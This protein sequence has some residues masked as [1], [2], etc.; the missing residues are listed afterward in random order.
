MNTQ[1][2]WYR[3][4]G[5]ML[6]FVVAAVVSLKF[7][8]AAT[9]SYVRLIVCAICLL[10]VLTFASGITG[11]K[12][13]L[14]DEF[15]CYSLQRVITFGWFVVLAS[16]F[17]GISF[18][19]IAVWVTPGGKVPFFVE[20][21][22]SIWALAGVVLGGLV[23]NGV[24]NSVHATTPPKDETG[25]RESFLPP[26]PR[27]EG[28]MYRNIE[29]DDAKPGDIAKNSQFGVQDTVDMTAVQQLLFQAAVLV[30]Y[31]VAVGRLVVATASDKPIDH[32]PGLPPEL[33]ALLGVS[34]LAQVG[35]AAIPKAKTKVEPVAAKP[36]ERFWT[37]GK[38]LADKRLRSRKVRP[39]VWR[40]TD[41]L[42][43]PEC[44]GMG[45]VQAESYR[46]G[47]GSAAREGGSD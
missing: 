21:E 29:V 30:A 38:E 10:G 14:I 7:A 27:R 36:T 11:M 39:G 4:A 37:E 1:A 25:A 31:V 3:I 26:E 40:A 44:A 35:N 45:F 47:Q 42:R 24:V 16:A 6:A 33:L 12:T 41:H 9:S 8:E 13:A 5:A 2:N 20:I 34:T 22:A 28:S 19:N 46:R 17:L 15:N 23:G 43:C 18:W 32:L